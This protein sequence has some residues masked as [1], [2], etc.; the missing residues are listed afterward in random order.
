MEELTEG[1]TLVIVGECMGCMIIMIEKD[2]DMGCW[3]GTQVFNHLLATKDNL[4]MFKFPVF[5][6]AKLATMA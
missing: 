5:M 6:V 3:D 4:T 2:N 1:E